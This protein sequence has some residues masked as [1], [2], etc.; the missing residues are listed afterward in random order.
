MIFNER[1]IKSSISNISG[2]DYLKT[3]DMIN[4]DLLIVGGMNKISIINVNQ[5]KLVRII[6]ANNSKINGFL[7]INKNIFLTGDNNGTIMQ[8][9]IEGDNLILISK[10]EKAHDKNI[11]SFIKIGNGHIASCSFDKSIKIW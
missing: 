2:N 9:K 10:K 6:D 7:M 4:K 11:C 8:W 5:Y 1:K 3:F